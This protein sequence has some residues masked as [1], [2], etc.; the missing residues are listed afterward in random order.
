MEDP[1]NRL[2][3]R[4]ENYTDWDGELNEIVHYTRKGVNGRDVLINILL[5]DDL[6]IANNKD[7]IFN[8]EFL[9]FG[10]KI[11]INHNNEYCVVMNYVSE[12]GN[13]LSNPFL[14]PE[15]QAYTHKRN[16]KE[17]CRGS[18]PR[19]IPIIPSE[20]NVIN[21]TLLTY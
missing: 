13:N 6:E 16:G 8:D 17:L 3:E 20:Y 10:I 5:S 12:L 4:V 19:S 11:G 14:K 9:Y 18:E 2:A 21:I 7:I 15:R 1:E